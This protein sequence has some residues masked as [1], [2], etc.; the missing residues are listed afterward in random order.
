LLSLDDLT[1]EISESS[2]KSPE[3]QAQMNE[4]QRQMQEA[5]ARLPEKNRQVIQWYYFEEKSLEEIGEKLGMSKSWICRVH[6]K[7]VE[8]LRDLILAPKS[9][10]VPAG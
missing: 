6:A 9:G 10:K 5:M 2:D 4:E 1:E 7:S 3:L 8:M